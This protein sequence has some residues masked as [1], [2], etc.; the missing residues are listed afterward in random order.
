MTASE[1][2]S[3]RTPSSS[4][5]VGARGVVCE[6]DKHSKHSDQILCEGLVCIK[7]SLKKTRSNESSLIWG[8]QI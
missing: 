7:E 3:V 8:G 4:D 1:R 6:M 2:E 5:F